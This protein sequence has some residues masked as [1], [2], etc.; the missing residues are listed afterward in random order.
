MR[1][2][3]VAPSTW[4]A[5]RNHESKRQ[6]GCSVV[7]SSGR[8]CRTGGCWARVMRSP[9]AGR[10]VN[11]AR[12]VRPSPLQIKMPG[13][14]GKIQ[15]EEGRVHAQNGVQMNPCFQGDPAGGA[16][17]ARFRRSRDLPGDC[18]T[19]LEPAILRSEEREGCAPDWV[20]S[21]GAFIHARHLFLPYV[22]PHRFACFA[23]VP[24]G[25]FPGEVCENA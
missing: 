17:L 22:T 9:W 11:Q 2:C 16:G 23:L 24:G 5:R 21:C 1:S 3:G 12:G 20:Y 6:V 4:W 8:A 14:L 13:I 19:P 25:A 15:R 18:R 7:I 10:S